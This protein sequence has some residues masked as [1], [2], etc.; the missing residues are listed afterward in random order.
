MSRGLVRAAIDWNTVTQGTAPQPAPGIFDS[1]GRL[2]VDVPCCRCGY[3]LRSLALDGACPECGEHVA[4]SA[5][6]GRLCFSPWQWLRRMRLGLLLLLLCGPFWVVVPAVIPMVIE[7]VNPPGTVRPQI[8]LHG[9]LVDWVARLLL[10]GVV[11]VGIVVLTSPDPSER[12]PWAERRWGRAL[13]LSVWVPALLLI[14]GV[15]GALG[16]IWRLSIWLLVLVYGLKVAAMAICAFAVPFML[17][18]FLTLLLGRAGNARLAK[19][20]DLASIG[21]LLVGF[22]FLFEAG[23]M[24]VFE[25][26]GEG[27]RPVTEVA[28]DVLW[29]A[30]P[31]SVCSAVFLLSPGYLC[32]ASVAIVL[33]GAMRDGR[34]CAEQTTKVDRKTGSGA[35]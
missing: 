30:F 19:F 16:M 14:A 32:L 33:T 23:V 2:A 31:L 4:A 17:L 27:P 8:V 24:V 12:A 20:A 6:E 3:N 7:L 10:W 1:S 9:L 15:A 34:R 35:R 13:R 28:Q 22:L 5:R 11:A 18:R 21:P 29:Y 26:F 25:V